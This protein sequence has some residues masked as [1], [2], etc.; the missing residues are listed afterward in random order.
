MSARF[1]LPVLV[2]GCCFALG[3]P[4]SPLRGQG[5][6]EVVPLAEPSLE[7]QTDAVRD[8]LI[9][10]RRQFEE[11]VRRDGASRAELAEAYGELGRLYFLYDFSDLAPVA[12]RNAVAYEP[13]ALQWRYLLAAHQTFEGALEEVEEQLRFLVERYPEHVPT[14]LR[15]GNLLVD[16]GRLDEAVPFF[17]GALA[18]EPDSAAAIAGLARIDRE[19]GRFEEAVQGFRRALELQPS[20]DSLYHPMALAYRALGETDKAREVIGLNK[21]GAVAFPDPIVESLARLNRSVDGSFHEAASAMR[22]GEMERATRL[23]R[24]YLEGQPND[25]IGHHNL[26]VALLASDGW[27]EGIA[28]LRKALELDPDY[29]GGHFSLG[30]AL[31]EEGKLEEA[32]YHYTRALE[33]DPEDSSVHAE[34]ATLLAKTGQPERA[35]EEL[36]K[37]RARRLE[38]PFVDLKYG[39]VLALLKRYDEAETVIAGLLAMD[40]LRPRTRAEALAVAGSLAEARRDVEAAAGFYAEASEL[41]TKDA[42]YAASLGR[43][44]GQLGR[45]GEAADALSRALTIRGAIGQGQTFSEELEFARATALILS[46]RYAEARAALEEAS[47]TNR[48]PFLHALAR[49]LATC[50]DAAVRDGARAVELADR[51]LSE[52]LT[53]QHAETMAMALAESGRFEEAQ[54]LQARVLEQ[55]QRMGRAQG[56]EHQERLERARLYRDRQPVRAP[57]QRP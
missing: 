40:K 12:L 42:D 7:S 25:P 57:W 3:A 16:S 30:S 10:A 5:E 14:K 29:R 47:R 45:F 32:L 41:D 37:L 1:L 15:L 33:I 43:V 52:E 21:H 17:E 53:L 54:Q 23:Y 38:E 2:A 9:E 6:L 34:W 46:A 13:D 51:V 28:A 4:A 35:L 18:R 26:G 55:A 27:N 39:S 50:P 36:A 56:T 11:I 48:I 22:R 20:A 8:Q 24:K 49:L 31:A 44:L 19:Q